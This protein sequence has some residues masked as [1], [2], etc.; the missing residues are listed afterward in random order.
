MCSNCLKTKMTPSQCEL[1]ARP[2][3]RVSGQKA[4]QGC[5][6]SCQYDAKTL[7]IIN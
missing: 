7:R 4:G 3:S 5:Q 2:W 1:L 6:E